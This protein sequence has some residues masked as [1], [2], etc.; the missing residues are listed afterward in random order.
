[1]VEMAGTIDTLGNDDDED[2]KPYFSDHEEDEEEEDNV[3]ITNSMDFKPP[4]RRKSRGRPRKYPMKINT[5]PKRPRGR[6]R[7]FP[8]LGRLKNDICRHM[9][10]FY[11]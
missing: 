7:K 11:M 9:F 2:Y 6:P 8:I 4:L 3:S 5:G 10:S 1:M